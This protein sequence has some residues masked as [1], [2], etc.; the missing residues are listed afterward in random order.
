MSTAKYTARFGTTNL[1]ATIHASTCNVVAVNQGK[2]FVC[3]EVEGAT[4]KEAAQA[5]Y[6]GEGFEARGLKMPTICACA[7]V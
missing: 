1:K 6:D 2:K 3:F 4:A 5:V 7:K